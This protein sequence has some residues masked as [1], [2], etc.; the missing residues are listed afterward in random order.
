M[1]STK[2]F[3]AAILTVASSVAQAQ[4]RPDSPGQSGGNAT[5]P[6]G[7][8]QGFVSVVIEDT[9]TETSLFMGMS[10]RLAPND[11]A[12][13]SQGTRTEVTTTTLEVTVSGPKGQVDKVE[14]IADV[15]K[16]QNCEASEPR[17][18]SETTEVTDLPG[19]N[20]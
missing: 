15:D 16:C 11:R 12:A 2:F 8:D 3:L 10:E 5:N 19:A 4:G 6:G 7:Q 20:R 17:V 1:K 13:A 14:T 9:T 18:V